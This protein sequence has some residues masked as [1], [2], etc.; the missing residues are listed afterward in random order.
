MP[1]ETAATPKPC[2]NPL[3]EACGPSR[4]AAAM[5]AWT[6]RQPVMRDQGQRRTPRPLPR[7][8]CRSRLQFADTMHHGERIEQGRGDGHGTE[9][10]RLTLLAEGA[11]LAVG[12]LGFPQE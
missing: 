10:P 12:A 9:D 6:A 3:G 11:H 8:G 2:R 1:V 7:R 5:T 4:P